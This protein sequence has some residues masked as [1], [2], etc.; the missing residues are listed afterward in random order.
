MIRG[1]TLCQD[2]GDNHF[3]RT[4]P[5]QKTGRLV[6]QIA[7]LGFDCTIIPHAWGKVSI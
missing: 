5:E 6:R 4:S 7:K 2:L 3:N 1:G